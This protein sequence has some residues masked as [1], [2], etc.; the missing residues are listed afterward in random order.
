MSDKKLSNIKKPKVFYCKNC[1]YPSSYPSILS[2]DDKGICSGCNVS[3]ERFEINFDERLQK[4]KKI[5]NELKDKGN[6][7]YDCLIPVSGGK[8]SFLKKDN[9][10]GYVMDQAKLFADSGTG[11]E[12]T[13]P[14]GM[15]EWEAIKL[16]DKVDVQ[17]A[18][19]VEDKGAYA[20]DETKFN[21]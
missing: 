6:S 21:V 18:P 19:T 16:Y 7:H 12:R 8:D 14:Q 15:A 13:H 10:V 17:L 1:V 3:S 5:I 20:V 2:F 9:R 11:I 4:L